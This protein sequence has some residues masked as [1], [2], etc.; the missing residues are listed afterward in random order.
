M[1]HAA[2]LLPCAHYSYLTAACIAL[3]ADVRVPCLW[4]PPT[5]YYSAYN[6]T[7]KAGRGTHRFIATVVGRINTCLELV[8]HSLP[9]R[10]QNDCDIRDWPTLSGQYPDSRIYP[11][12]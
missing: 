1:T 8:I 12:R 9:R 5:G 3:C 6:K 10:N 4:D 7:G 2:S 11:H